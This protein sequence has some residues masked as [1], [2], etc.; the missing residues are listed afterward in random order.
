M[1]DISIASSVKTIGGSAFAHCTNLSEITIPEGVENIATSAFNWSGLTKINLP[2][3]LEKGE[4]YFS[5]GDNVTIHFDDVSYGDYMTAL[6][7]N[8]DNLQEVNISNDDYVSKKGVV[9]DTNNRLVSYPRARP[10]TEYAVPEG[11]TGIITLAFRGANNLKK[12]TIPSS[13]NNISFL[14][15]IV[16]NVAVSNLSSYP[17]VK[18]VNVSK[19]LVEVNVDSNNTTYTSENGIVFT[20]DKTQ[21]VWYPEGKTIT[22]YTVPSS[23]KTIG[24]GAFASSNNIQTIHLQEGLEKIESSAFAYCENLT[25]VD[26]PSTLKNIGELAFRN[27]FKLSIINLPESIETIGSSA[28]SDCE[29]LTNVTIPSNI[30]KIESSTFSNT[31][32][33]NVVIPIGVTTIEDS[34]F[35]SCTSLQ[36]IVIPSTVKNIGSNILRYIRNV[37][38]YCQT[39]SAAQEYAMNKQIAYV[40]DDDAPQIESVETTYAE[41]STS[42]TVKVTANDQVVGL[43]PKAYSFDGGKTWQESNE[44][45]YKRNKTGVSV[46]VR[47]SLGNISTYETFDITEIDESQIV[48]QVWYIGADA[49]NEEAVV[50]TLRANGTLEISGTGNMKNW[51]RSSSVPWYGEDI[52]EVQIQS[53]VTNI[54]NYAFSECSDITSVTI[55][56]GV[57]TIG[58]NAFSGCSNLANITIPS[59]V[60]SIGDNAFARCI[61][62]VDIKIPEG[63]KTIGASAFSKCSNLES[64]TIPSTVDAILNN[65][66]YGC[67][68]LKNVTIAN[69]ITSIGQSAFEGCSS[70][71]QITIPT[72]VETIGN[73]AF[74]NCSSLSNIVLSEGVERINESAFKNCTSLTTIEIPSTVTNINNTAFNGCSSLQN[75]NV[76]ENNTAYSSL[77]GVLFNKNKTELICHPGAR[78]E[79][80]Y[81]IP[82]TVKTIG[83]Y[84]FENSQN[85]TNVTIPD[86]VTTIGEGAFS[87]CTG[88]NEYTIPNSVT[89]IGAYAFEN[90]SNLRNIT[91]SENITIIN[92]YT[93][94]GC[95]NLESVTI[96]DNVTAIGEG[97]FSGCGIREIII[98]EG[99][100]RIDKYA[101][102]SCT[103]LTNVDIPLTLA[104]IGESAFANC[105]GLDT[106]VIPKMVAEIGEN[107][108]AEIEDL[109]IYCGSNSQAEQYAI[110]NEIEYVIDDDAPEIKTVTQNP[111]GW[112]SEGVTITVDAEDTGVGLAQKPYRFDGRNY[113]T[114]N[115][116][117]YTS[118]TTIYNV[119]VVDKIGNTATY[120][121]TITI[122]NVD[123]VPP[124]ITNISQESAENTVTVTVNA[125]DSQSGLADE[126]YSFDGGRNW[127]ASNQKE[128]SKAELKIVVVVRD[129]AGN[130]SESEVVLNGEVVWKIGAENVEDVIAKLDSE[131]NL[132]ISGAGNMK[133]W[134]ADEPAPWENYKEQ[135]KSVEIQDGVTNVGDYAFS[136][137]GNLTIV[138]MPEGVETIG[139]GAFENCT[140]LNDVTIPESTTTIG[141]KAFHN[142]GLTQITVPEKVTQIGENA[143]HTS[144]I[145]DIHVDVNNENYSDIDGV[146]YNKDKTILIYY[147]AGRKDT[148]Y[149]IPSG[150]TEIQGSAFV[151]ADS[152]TEIVISM[153][154]TTIDDK[155][156]SQC[157][158]LNKIVI[159]STVTNIGT[160]AIDNCE[161]VTI[162]CKTGSEAQEYAT[163][164]QIACVI[165]DE[166]PDIINQ[167]NTPTTWTNGTVTMRIT[168]QDAKSGIIAC[169]FTTSSNVTI[170]STG[171]TTRNNT[172]EQISL[173]STATQNRTYYFYVMDALGNITK[174]EIVVENI[175][176]VRPTITTVTGN[177]TTWTREEVT[178]TIEA[179]DG[180]SGIASYSFD[181]GA[182]WQQSNSKTFS[183]NKQGIII[184]VKDAAGNEATYG[185]TINITRIDKTPPTIN[186][187]NGIPSGI[188]TRNVTLT[189]V[190]EDELNGSGLAKQAYSFDNGA[191]WQTSNS[192]TYNTTGKYE[193]TIKVRDEAGNE[194]TYETIHMEIQKTT[195]EDDISSD[196][197]E[198]D[199]PYITGVQPE[200]TVQDFKDRIDANGNE[201]EIVGPGNETLS[202]TDFITTGTQVIVPDKEVYT[203]VVWGDVT[204]DGKV[205]QWDLAAMNRHRILGGTDPLYALKNEYFM[206][207][208]V[209]VE[210]GVIDQWDMS[211]I[212]KYMQN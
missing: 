182:T 55:A 153:S 102:E 201:I 17:G 168:T 199:A 163:N 161:N 144:V 125:A 127:Q 141:S 204:G 109:T 104:T 186:T 95:S 44:K 137:C 110:N 119:Y 140:S 8:C 107:A 181:N 200:T 90:N 9:F 92:E 123:T 116:K 65:T 146:L 94:S 53:G 49:S 152:L 13:L 118:N 149:N 61:S 1:E 184:K 120:S 133:D 83:A 85:L 180:E 205:D 183:E 84:A 208:D 70:L 198:I 68:N 197:Y 10:A 202:D 91:L 189:I 156:I 130:T 73:S 155:A 166:G 57:T 100:T 69:G 139:E 38:I 2:S 48:E 75:I 78:E 122:D 51:T 210:K 45:T 11:T 71:E 159:P 14:E 59:T 128:I 101:F 19:N 47:D 76:H 46:Q 54:G 40:T 97:A 179:Q 212:N 147:P 81:E 195:S 151:E 37:T 36:K 185:Q 87:G 106:I 33:T 172:V 80:A 115:T 98:P 82:S 16:L 176:K 171:W 117:T 52:V 24:D 67:E 96:P 121:Q 32:L 3:T 112:T 86:G 129:N 131:G 193:I 88:I 60:T 150:V 191:T 5:T 12:I 15:S 157:Q 63:V 43:A 192:K 169:Q 99:V 111:E 21:L 190:A 158:N 42:A 64:V 134:N 145:T 27:C 72:T 177:P 7:F 148:S 26:L 165:D 41:D 175:D 154:V 23:V 178:L 6:L 39:G 93:F 143:F 79:Q 211:T 203:V 114:E 135:I 167:E 4:A 160:T 170:D 105:T 66:F 77:N 124:V 196:Y 113:Q 22:E 50:A 173:E 126:A 35:A 174:Q 206:A 187:V 30:A 28:F 25:E 74:A 136:D 29:S 164:N 207:G 188:S 209:V 132:V 20:K 89:N 138:K 34:A 56:N 194:T 31:N 58:K 108:F 142:T 62:L 103:S 18:N 162:Y